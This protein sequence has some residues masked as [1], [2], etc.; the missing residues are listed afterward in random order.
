M[1]MIEK[2]TFEEEW[3]LY[4]EKDLVWRDIFCAGSRR[5]Y[6][7]GRCVWRGNYCWIKDR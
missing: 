3:A 6:P 1:R 4:G 7:A 5:N 2:Q